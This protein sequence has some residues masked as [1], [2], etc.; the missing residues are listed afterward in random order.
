MGDI[1][2][3]LIN[4]DFDF[5]TGEYIGNG[6]GYPRSYRGNPTDYVGTNSR[7]KKGLNKY[8]RINWGY[9]QDKHSKIVNS[10]LKEVK[11]VS[12]NCIKTSLNSKAS[13]VQ[14]DWNSF[15]KWCNKN[16]TKQY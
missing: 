2:E 3:G 9:P 7:D 12:N 4:G 16:L 14:Q 1:A 15:A 8:L 13:L 11:M 10:Y 5:Y 6:G